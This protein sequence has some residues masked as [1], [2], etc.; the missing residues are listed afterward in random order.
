MKPPM[1]N[2]VT[3][4]STD[5]TKAA[6]R[7]GE[8]PKI[9]QSTLG[10]V[11]LTTKLVKNVQGQFVQASLEVDLPPEIDLSEGDSIEAVDN[12]GRK[13]TGKIISIDEATNFAG[14]RTFYRTVYCG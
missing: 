13:Q 7:H 11:A 2:Q 3:V 12:Q 9:S 14:N 5:M 6:D 8:R 10:R 4:Y 1:K